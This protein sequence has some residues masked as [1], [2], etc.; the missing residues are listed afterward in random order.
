MPRV[1]GVQ[2]DDDKGFRVDVG[3]RNRNRLP[4][5][6]RRYWRVTIRAA[7]PPGADGRI[8]SGAAIGMEP[9]YTPL[10]WAMSFFCPYDGATEYRTE[11]QIA[12]AV[13]AARVLWFTGRASARVQ[14]RCAI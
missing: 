9:A 8:Q 7:D 12:A 3:G 2:D 13:L 4:L 6:R 14:H 11:L 1:Y 10:L 5:V